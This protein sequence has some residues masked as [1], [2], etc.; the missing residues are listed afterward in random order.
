MTELEGKTVSETKIDGNTYKIFP[1]DLNSNGMV[2]G[3]LVMSFLDRI[4]LVVA[5]RHSEKVCVTASVDALHFLAPAKAGD[6]LIF[7][8][9]INRTWKTSMEVGVKVEAES[10]FSGK[11][12]H[13]VSAYFTFVAVDDKNTPCQVPPLLPES[14]IEQRRYLEAG[15]RRKNRMDHARD[16]SQRRHQKNTFDK[17]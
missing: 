7:K 3:G 2:F 12:I 4:A 9:A 10:P 16:I 15:I 5:E 13:V 8:A 6:I 14:E 1:N 11:H 17:T